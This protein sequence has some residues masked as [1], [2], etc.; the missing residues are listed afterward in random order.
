MNHADVEEL[1]V[2]DRY[3]RGRLAEEEAVQFEQHYLSCPACL[4]HLEAA[5]GLE[6][7]LKRAVAQDATRAVQVAAARQLAVVAWLTRL[8]RSRQAALLATGLLL[9]LL[10]PGLALRRA[11]ELGR[12]LQQTRSALAAERADGRPEGDADSARLRAAL[13]ESRRDLARER[14]TAADKIA[15]AEQAAAAERGAARQPQ[16]NLPLLFL[17]PQR[18]GPEPEPAHRL[19]LPARPGWAVLSLTVEPPHPPSYRV[20]LRGPGGREVWGGADLHPDAL[21][22]LT[23]GLPTELL[24]PG[25]YLLVVEGPAGGRPASVARFPFRVLPPA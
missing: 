18:G 16:V 9:V 15:A 2:V 6:R 8:G 19:R 5:E 12:E 10:V 17:E 22:V 14:Q 20:T 25:D 7:G 13:E 1:E 23:L 4:D 11:G 24:A 21:D 3:L